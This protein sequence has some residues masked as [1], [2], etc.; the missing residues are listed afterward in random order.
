MLKNKQFKRDK[1]LIKMDKRYSKI[2]K[3][4]E[5]TKIYIP[6]DKPVQKGNYLYLTLIDNLS[7]DNNE[8]IKFLIEHCSD[9]FWVE[10]RKDFNKNYKCI[11]GPNEF[12]AWN[13]KQIDL[14]S[15]DL[16]LGVLLENEY[17]K[18]IKKYPVLEYYISGPYERK[19]RFNSYNVYYVNNIH[20]GMLRKKIEKAYIYGYYEYDKQLLSEKKI[21]SDILYENP[22]NSGRLGKIFGYGSNRWNDFDEKSQRLKAKEELRCEIGELDFDDL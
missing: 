9:K 12:F 15:Y 4:L 6:F 13:E 2:V 17:L 11:R 22:E 1:D 3:E 7:H 10:N 21:L 20:N 5:N 19:T 18:M 14:N 8:A 16:K